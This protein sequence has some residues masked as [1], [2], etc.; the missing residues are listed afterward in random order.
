MPFISNT[1][2]SVLLFPSATV[3]CHGTKAIIV[4]QQVLFSIN[5]IRRTASVIATATEQQNNEQQ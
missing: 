4:S 2:L 1:F 3:D 5:T